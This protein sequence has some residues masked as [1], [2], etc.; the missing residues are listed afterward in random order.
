[1]VNVMHAEV[2]ARSSGRYSVAD[3]YCGDDQRT[4]THKC[5]SVEAV[6]DKIK[7]FVQE[8]NV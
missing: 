2:R 4:W 1:M 5:C 6:K 7:V 3:Y 8:D